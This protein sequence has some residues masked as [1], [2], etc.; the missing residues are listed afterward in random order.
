[1]TRPAKTPRKRENDDKVFTNNQFQPVA[2]KTEKQKRLLQAAKDFQIVTALGS[3]GTG[4]TY[5]LVGYA[6]QLLQQGKISKIVVT[7]PY[8]TAVGEAYGF[9]SGDIAEKFAWVLDPVRTILEKVLGKS[10]VEYYIKTKVIEGIPLGFM[11]GRTFESSI[12]ICD[13]MQNSTPEAMELVL[14]RL[15]GDSKCFITGDLEQQDVKGMSGLKVASKYLSW[16]PCYKQIEFSDEDIV[17]S[18][19]TADILKSFREYRKDLI[20]S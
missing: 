5:I 4:K 7:R 19:I 14:T 1:M 3:A 6:A 18:H 10:L 13:E 12:V 8:E 11:R 9:L 17:R 15:G 16:M 20:H 2:A